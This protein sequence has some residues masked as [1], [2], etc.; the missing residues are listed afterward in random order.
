MSLNHEQRW[1]VNEKE[2]YYDIVIDH[3]HHIPLTTKPVGKIRLIR[4]N[5]S[6]CFIPGVVGL[7]GKGG[8]KNCWP[9]NSYCLSLLC[10]HFSGCC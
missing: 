6:S 3:S 4:T 7:T 10:V 9:C 5:N 8:M 2:I 1:V